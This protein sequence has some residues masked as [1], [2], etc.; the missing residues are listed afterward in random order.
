[1]DKQEIIEQIKQHEEELE[2]LKKMK[3]ADDKKN[4][5][6]YA[7]KLKAH[8][9]AEAYDSDGDTYYVQSLWVD[10]DACLEFNFVFEMSSDKFQWYLEAK[11]KEQIDFSAV[12]TDFDECLKNW[13]EYKD[14]YRVANMRGS[15][16]IRTLL[17]DDAIVGAVLDTLDVYAWDLEW[18]PVEPSDDDE[19]ESVL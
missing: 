10:A 7:E 17:L 13:L 2:L 18:T 4:I 14:R 16:E 15:I 9:F 12:F 8:G 3:D 5:A 19:N 1:M 11:Y 6:L